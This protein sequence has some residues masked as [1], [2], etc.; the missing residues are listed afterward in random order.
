MTDFMTQEQRKR[1]MSHVKGKDTIPEIIIR[2][3]LWQAG[4]R[5]SLKS[6]LPGKPD[7]VLP[8][9]RAVIFVH[10]CFWHSH[11]GC[12]KSKLPST[13]KEFWTSKITANVQ[14]DKRNVSELRKM[15]WRVAVIWECSLKN[16]NLQ[17]KSFIALQEWIFSKSD[18]F[19]K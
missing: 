19:E 14:R 10:G 13:R 9:Y 11:P 17:E 18:T 8:K 6:K 1:C 2:K 15:G 12:Q 3:A 16:L 4:F 5:Y 7:I